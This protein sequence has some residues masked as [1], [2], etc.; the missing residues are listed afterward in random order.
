MSESDQREINLWKTFKRVIKYGFEI[1]KL[2]FASIFFTF[3]GVGFKL[4]IPVVFSAFFALAQRSLGSSNPGLSGEVINLSILL[5]S[6]YLADGISNSYGD[7]IIGKWWMST[8]NLVF[9]K[10]YAH[11]TSL[12]IRFYEKNPTGKIRERVWDGSSAIVHILEHAFIN[13]LPQ[14]LF[15][16]MAIVILLFLQPIFAFVILGFM[17]IYFWVS[18]R[19]FK[20]LKNLQNTNRERWENLSTFVTESIYNSKTVKTY[21]TENYHINKIGKYTDKAFESEIDWQKTNGWSRG[22]RS[23]IMNIVRVSTIGLGFYMI[24]NG[25]LEIAGFILVW[26]YVMQS[27][28]PISGM[29]RSIDNIQKLLVGT[30]LTFE[31]LDTVPSIKDVP[32]AKPLKIEK[33]D[34]KFENI[35]F[36]YKDRKVIDNFS[37]EIPSNK[38][39]AIVGKSG[40][41]K[42]TLIKLLLR[43]YDPQKGNIFIDNKNIKNFTQKSI[44]DNIAVVMQDSVLFNDTVLNN[45]AYSKEGAS[46]EEVIR[47]AK[48]AHADEFINRLPGKYNSMV[49]EKGLKLSGGEQQRINIAR[50]VLRN[51]PILVFDEATSS[52]DSEN[53]KLIHDAM[54]HLMKGKTTIIIAHRLST[55][56]E[57][58]IIIVMDKG[59]VAE[60][61]TH[62]DLVAQKGGIYAKLFEIQSGGYIV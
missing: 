50:A 48:V 51:S 5:F 9:K 46:K 33:G 27:L 43:L 28:D 29:A 6:V 32:N 35:N 58:D 45:I 42:S 38:V 36:S 25:Q 41:G 30:A 19:Y 37:L 22:I 4:L 12:S 16:I 59:K 20:K 7:F 15:I 8:Q 26:N 62:E 53:E 54:E 13:I 61:G 57:A 23:I 24:I 3:L 21:S 11:I 39:V 44:R 14:M 49:G 18:Y 2:F 60:I 10:L 31:Y 40:S 52:L 55:I 56:M 34:I 17:P 47:A 1:K